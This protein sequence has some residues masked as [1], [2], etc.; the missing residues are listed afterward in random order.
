MSE[1]HKG[2]EYRKR[3]GQSKLLKRTCSCETFSVCLDWNKKPTNHKVPETECN[4]FLLK[5]RG[6]CVILLSVFKNLE[7]M[8]HLEIW[9]QC[10]HFQIWARHASLVACETPLQTCV[11]QPME[12]S[13]NSNWKDFKEENFLG[14]SKLKDFYTKWQESYIITVIA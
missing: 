8:V 11:N 5:N 13:I 6:M 2:K 7:Q 10:K 9:I 14:A 4:G 12:L 1:H 3:R